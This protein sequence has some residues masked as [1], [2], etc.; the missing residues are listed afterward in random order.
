MSYCRVTGGNDGVMSI[1]KIRKKNV[2]GVIIITVDGNPTQATGIRQIK[3]G[4][5]GLRVG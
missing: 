3:N 4:V 5:S 2:F 1:G